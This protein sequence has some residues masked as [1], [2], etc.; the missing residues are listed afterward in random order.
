MLQAGNGASNTRL[1]L[2][3]TAGTATPLINSYFKVRRLSGANVGT[4]VA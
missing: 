2:T 4:Y 3:S 1:R